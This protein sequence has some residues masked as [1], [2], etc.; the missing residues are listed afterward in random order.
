MRRFWLPHL[1]DE[2]EKSVQDTVCRNL[3][4]DGKSFREAKQNGDDRNGNFERIV[5]VAVG[6]IWGRHCL[7]MEKLKQ[8]HT[9]MDKILSAGISSSVATS[10]LHFGHRSLV[11]NPLPTT[12]HRPPNL[13]VPS[14]A[15]NAIPDF[16][17]LFNLSSESTP[18]HSITASSTSNYASN[19]HT[20]IVSIQLTPSSD[21]T[22]SL[23]LAVPFQPSAVTDAEC[24]LVSDPTAVLE[25]TCSFNDF[26]V[27]ITVSNSP[28]ERISLSFK[29]WSLNSLLPYS[30]RMAFQR[31]ALSLTPLLN[32]TEIDTK[33]ICHATKQGTVT[34]LIASIKITV[35][36]PGDTT[37]FRIRVPSITRTLTGQDLVGNI[38]SFPAC[39]KGSVFAEDGDIH[40]SFVG[41]G[42]DLN[43]TLSV[44]V[45]V[46][47]P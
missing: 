24:H 45:N 33:N 3:L 27:G 19:V 1:V 46:F 9:E 44:S 40:C 17:S 37:K 23:N 25:I 41:N 22:L 47:D 21:G 5:R 14:L 7:K 12:Q 8:R 15:Q 39:T 32:I 26:S 18:E 35:T 11:S 42:T 43:Y 29:I 4:C 34:V 36:V 13:F 10:T 20:T 16:S 31:V 30:P 38:Q 6:K 28:M 2:T